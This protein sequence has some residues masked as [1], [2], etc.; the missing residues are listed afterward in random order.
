MLSTALDPHLQSKLMQFAERC[1]GVSVV[2]SFSDAVTH[3]VVETDKRRVLKNRTMKYLQGIISK[4]S[5]LLPPHSS[6]Y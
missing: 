5:Q 2:N 4:C 1:E 6:C 3:I